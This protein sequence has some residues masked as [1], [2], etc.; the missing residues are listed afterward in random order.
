MAQIVSKIIDKIRGRKSQKV[1]HFDPTRKGMLSEHFSIRELSCRCGCAR[2]NFNMDTLVKLERARVLAGRPFRIASGCR[3]DSHN[4][5]EGG[6]KNSAHLIGKAVDIQCRGSEE[7]YHLLESLG[8]EFNRLGIA[9]T[10]IHVD[11]DDRKPSKVI[12][13]Y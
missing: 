12:W 1:W 4:R 13:T 10:F 6:L 7:R 11:D 5:D 8:Q 3:C 9:S 2:M